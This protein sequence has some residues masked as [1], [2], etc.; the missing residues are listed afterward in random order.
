MQQVSSLSIRIPKYDLYLIEAKIT[1]LKTKLCYLESVICRQ[2]TAETERR[3]L[4]K[5]TT[6]SFR[7]ALKQRDEILLERDM[8]YD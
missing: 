1:T 6:A 2:Y 7:D 4:I 8:F 5:Q 3:E